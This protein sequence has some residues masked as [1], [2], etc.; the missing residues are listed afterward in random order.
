MNIDHAR[1]FE[2]ERRAVFK[3]LANCTVGYGGQRS[4]PRVLNRILDEVLRFD[5]QE[6][7]IEVSAEDSEVLGQV[8]RRN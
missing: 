3:D 2:N 6:L 1:A 5:P 8:P 7:L 4:T